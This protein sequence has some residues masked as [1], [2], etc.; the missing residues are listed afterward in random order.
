MKYDRQ[1]GRGIWPVVLTPFID[2]GAIDFAS[3]RN[4][5]EWYIGNGVDGLF[6]VC[7][8]SELYQ[9][10]ASERLELAKSPSTSPET[11]FRWSPRPGWG[12]PRRKS[13]NP[14]STWPQQEWTQW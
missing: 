6:A 1:L 10:T 13:C 11:V 8:S 3:Y 12:V 5:L 9:L 2:T 14:S 7:L 4:L